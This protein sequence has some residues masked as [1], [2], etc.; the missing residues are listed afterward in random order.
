MKL[1]VLNNDRKKS[2][3]SGR[4][5]FDHLLLPIGIRLNQKTTTMVEPTPLRV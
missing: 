2:L 3:A 4:F 1:S 5:L